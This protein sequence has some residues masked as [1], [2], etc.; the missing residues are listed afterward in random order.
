MPIQ[1]P[2]QTIIYNLSN[3]KVKIS[4]K[5]T[6]PIDVDITSNN[7]ISVNRTLYTIKRDSQII[8]QK[9]GRSYFIESKG[10]LK[11]YQL[12]Q[13]DSR[14]RYYHVGNHIVP[15][16]NKSLK[17]IEP[18]ITDD[19]IQIGDDVFQINSKSEII[20]EMNGKVFL[21]NS[22]KNLSN[23]MVQYHWHFIIPAT[24]IILLFQII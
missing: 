12:E 17:D 15:I 5:S 11:R 21:I 22:S 20:I 3:K 1:N 18:L 24:I 8:I 7:T 2:K 16:I 13:F 6:S 19:T 4:N 23:Y 10:D 14:I 9:N